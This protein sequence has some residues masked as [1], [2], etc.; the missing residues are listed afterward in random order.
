MFRVGVHVALAIFRGRVAIGD[1]NVLPDSADRLSF[2]AS[3]SDIILAM[4]GVSL[5]NDTFGDLLCHAFLRGVDAVAD[6]DPAV[7]GTLLF[8]QGFAARAAGRAR[9]G[10]LPDEF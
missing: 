3:C 6:N 10:A 7:G 9:H 8:F 2:S 1:S 4:D 5:E